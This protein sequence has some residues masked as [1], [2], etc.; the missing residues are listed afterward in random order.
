MNCFGFVDGTVRP[1]SRP[2]QNQRI[3]FNGH[4]RI[5]ALKF[6]SVVIPNGLIFNLH[7]PVE[8]RR[9]DS[10]MLAESR[11]LGQLQLHAYT[12]NGEPP[13]IYGDPAYPLRVYLQAPYQGNRLTNLQKRYNTTMS[14]VRVSVE[15]LF[16]EILTYFAFADFKRNL[17]TALS[18]IGKMYVVC[19]L[20]TNA[21]IC[22]YKSRTSNFFDAEPPMLEK[23][24]N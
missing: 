11:L 12:P 2:G 16:K 17:T 15:W 18:A 6:Q 13:C 3:L 14:N 9:H 4:K 20:L 23:Y 21:R 8:G 19:T 5:H 7:G 1:C 22:L 24:F 10:G